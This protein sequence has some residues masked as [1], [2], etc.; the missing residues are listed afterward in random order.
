MQSAG[1]GKC[2][3]LESGFHFG[4]TKAQDFMGILDGLPINVVQIRR[5]K[6]EHVSE[7][8]QEG[9]DLRGQCISRMGSDAYQPCAAKTGR[10]AFLANFEDPGRRE[11][12][13]TLGIERDGSVSSITLSDFCYVRMPKNI[14]G[15]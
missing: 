4:T 1:G 7:F 3:P 9:D 8:M 10:A 2:V 15:T 6:I 13:S 11:E 14:L 12:K 5:E